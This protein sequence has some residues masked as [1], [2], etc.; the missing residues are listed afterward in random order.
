MSCKAHLC[1]K[2]ICLLCYS[3]APVQK[4]L[5]IPKENVSHAPP[6]DDQKVYDFAQD[7]ASDPNLYAVVDK[8]TQQGPVE[9]NQPKK[10]QASDEMPTSFGADSTQH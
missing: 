6:R 10:Y 5:G 7:R 4:Q 3:N 1:I 2:I 8:H 9:P